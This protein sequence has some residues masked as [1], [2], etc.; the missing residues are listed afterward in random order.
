M[1]KIKT[2]ILDKI[3]ILIFTLIIFSSTANADKITSNDVFTEVKIIQDRIHTIHKF[4]HINHIHLNEDDE[5]LKLDAILKPRN[6]WQ[7]TYEIMIK[8]NILRTKHNLPIIEPVNM[9]PVLHLS[10]ASV[11]EQTQ[12]ILTELNIFMLRLGIKNK[13]DIKALKY[14]NKKPLDIYKA[15][16]S[17]SSA[18][19]ELN[20]ESL[21]SSYVFGEMMRVYDDTTKIMQYLHIQDDTIPTKRYENISVNDTFKRSLQILNKIKYIQTSLGIESVSFYGF[22]KDELVSSDVFGMVQMI[23]AELQPIKASIGLNHYITPA[24]TQ[25]EN[26][27]SADVDQMMGWIL[28]KIVLLDREIREKQEIEK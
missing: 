23:I 12:R 16:S 20:K 24:A 7:K 19:D 4:F 13:D 22:K 28:R 25:Y 5:K 6:T 11:Y 18:L 27:T 14:H 21:T 3:I 17:V 10:P 15:L 1:C 9:D 2:T 8:I 26:K